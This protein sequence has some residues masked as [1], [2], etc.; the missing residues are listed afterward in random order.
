M[1]FGHSSRNTLRQARVSTAMPL[2]N[3]IDFAFACALHCDQLL[4]GSY[5]DG[6]ELPA[7]CLCQLDEASNAPAPLRG[8]EGHLYD[9]TRLQALSVPTTIHQHRWGACLQEPMRHLA[10]LIFGVQTDLY[11]RI[12]PLELRHSRVHRQ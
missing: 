12:R 8:I 6:T 4:F 11:V 5:A 1:R 9:V 10:L 7:V 2:T 3:R